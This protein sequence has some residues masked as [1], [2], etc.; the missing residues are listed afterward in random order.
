[1]HKRTF[2]IFFLVCFFLLIQDS[3][4]QAETSLRIHGSVG[5]SQMSEKSFGSGFWSGFG[6]SIP[7]NRDVHMSFNFGAW[8]SQ[9][10]S[11][12]DGLQ[13]GS[14]TVNPFFASL[15][16]FLKLGNQSIA[17]YVFV[18]GGYIFS[19]F[20]MDDVVTIPEISFSQKIENSP[21]GQIGAGIKI[22]VSKRISLTSDVSYFYSKTSGTTILQDLNFGTSTDEFS[23]RLNA[24]IFQLGIKFL[25]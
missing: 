17:P 23:L 18:G 20:R 4:G 5:L 2:Y 13:D 22:E 8:K 15:Y 14:L 24:I 11:N 21:G 19:S 16:Y 6:F 3:L 12:A 25:I 1:M 9:V 7:I 10:N